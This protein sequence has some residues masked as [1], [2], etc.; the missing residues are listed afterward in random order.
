MT[1][2]YVDGTVTRFG[3]IDV[4]ALTESKMVS[5]VERTKLGTVRPVICS[6]GRKFDHGKPDRSVRE[7][8]QAIDARGVSVR[9]DVRRLGGRMRQR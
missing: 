8:D 9:Y 6:T 1:R 3:E 2:V 5:A 4:E 7:S